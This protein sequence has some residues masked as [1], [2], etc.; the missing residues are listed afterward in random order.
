[1]IHLL[2]QALSA[3]PIIMGLSSFPPS[4][5]QK[6]GKE[7]ATELNGLG[8]TGSEVDGLNEPGSCVQS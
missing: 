8:T 4:P 2:T 5:T 3:S 7:K 6:R 1:M